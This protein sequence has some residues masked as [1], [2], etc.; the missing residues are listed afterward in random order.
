MLNQSMSKVPPLLLRRRPSI[1]EDNLLCRKRAVDESL[2]EEQW[3]LASWAQDSIKEGNLK[4]II[5]LGIKSE[6]SPKCLKEFVQVTRRCLHNNPKQ[7]PTMA[8]VVVSLEKLHAL[9]EK[10]NHL[11]QLEG[12]R[13][14]GK[15]ISV[16][17]SAFIEESYGQN[18]EKDKL[19][20]C[21]YGPD[22]EE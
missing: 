13:I 1:I 18:S 10:Y 5:D 11:M 21:C 14:F 16:L 3:N 6:I 17:S 4:P 22:D 2:D 7:R 9:Q 20:Y 12:K 19:G 8:E 15:M